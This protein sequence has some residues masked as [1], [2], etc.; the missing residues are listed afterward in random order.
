MTMRLFNPATRQWSIC[1]VD[2]QSVILDVP[3]TG[4]W[5]GNTG[6]FAGRDFFNGQ[7]I[8]FRFTWSKLGPDAARW[9]QEFSPDDGRTWEKNWI[10]VFTRL[11]D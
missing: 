2:N 6:V 1:W 3:V 10:M 11:L 5:R 9:E 7:P 4:E 8:M